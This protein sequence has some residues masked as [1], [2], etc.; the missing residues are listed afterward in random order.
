M[1]GSENCHDFVE[2]LGADM[3]IEVFLQLDDPSDLAR[4]CSVSSSWRQFVIA[5][6][7]FKQLCLKMFPEMSSVTRVIEVDDIIQPLDV[8][9]SDCIE[10][11][12]CKRNHS[13]YALLAQGLS[14]F[15]EKGCIS[16]AISASSTDNYPEESIRNTLVP[17]D[18]VA[19]VASY[20]SSKGQ[21]DPAVPETL[22]YRLIANLCLVTE[23]HVQPFQ[24][25]FLCR[26]LLYCRG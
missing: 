12:F 20:W 13:V 19:S 16:G 9:Q 8:R 21:S 23:I 17:S 10:W 6:A 3:S 7:L 15:L 2:W 26:T 18:R 1:S 22:V 5:N 24:G 11:E 14:P 25:C 4:V